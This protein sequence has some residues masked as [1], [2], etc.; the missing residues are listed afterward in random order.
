VRGEGFE[1]A[2][3]ERGRD[4]RVVAHLEMAV[5]RQ[6]VG[7]Q[8]QIGI[9]QQLQAALGGGVERARGAGPE[10]PVVH[11]DEVGALRART[12]EEVG[13]GADSGDHRLDLVLSGYL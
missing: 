10:E 6:V 7:G 11:Q 4:Q 8:R 13:V 3:A 9:E 12:R 1:L 2:R 5:E